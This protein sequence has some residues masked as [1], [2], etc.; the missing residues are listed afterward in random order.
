MQQKAIQLVSKWF[1]PLHIH[2]STLTRIR[3]ENKRINMIIHSPFQCPLLSTQTYMYLSN[4]KS[5]PTFRL[6][7]FTFK[8][9]NKSLPTDCRNAKIMKNR[10][11]ISSRAKRF[12]KRCQENGRFINGAENPGT[13]YE[14]RS[15]PEKASGRTGSPLHELGTSNAPLS[16]VQPGSMWQLPHPVPATSSE[17]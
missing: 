11:E 7:I 1:Q 13:P 6:S 2:I 12:S 15:A 5:K 4:P 14:F 10:G 17:T 9:S 8:I 3:L 16:S